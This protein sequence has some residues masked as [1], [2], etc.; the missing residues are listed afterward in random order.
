MKRVLA[1]CL[2]FASAAA[3]S[4]GAEA[5]TDRANVSPLL[6]V[7]KGDVVRVNDGAVIG[8]NVLTIRIGSAR[9]GAMF[10]GELPRS[11]ACTAEFRITKKVTPT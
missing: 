8:R 11:P 3:V 5:S 9:V 4:A 1:C 7:W 6:G 2:A 10:K